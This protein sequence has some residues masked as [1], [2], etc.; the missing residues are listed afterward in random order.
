MCGNIM[1]NDA[2][3]QADE[4]GQTSANGAAGIS[5]NLW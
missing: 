1:G 4:T 2:S 5:Y 3:L